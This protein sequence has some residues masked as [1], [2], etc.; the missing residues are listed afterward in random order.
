MWYST[1]LIKHTKSHLQYV[2]SEIWNLRFPKRDIYFLKLSISVYFVLVVICSN[3][4]PSQSPGKSLKVTVQNCY[5]TNQHTES[6]TYYYCVYQWS[7]YLQL[8]LHLWQPIKSC[9]ISE[10]VTQNSFHI[11]NLMAELG[12]RTVTQRTFLSSHTPL[13][14]SLLWDFSKTKFF[15]LYFTRQF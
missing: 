3:D 5:C 13:A 14:C 8:S 6:Q 15:H 1:L 9:L 11:C 10:L 2:V 12:L 7:L 4:L